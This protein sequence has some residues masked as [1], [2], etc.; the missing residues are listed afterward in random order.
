MTHFL[1][2][3]I[4]LVCAFTHSQ[5]TFHSNGLEVT[6]SDLELNTFQKDS[7]AN[8]LVIYEV[9]NSYVDKE[10]FKL[11]TEIKR[12]VKI[13]N[14]N[15]FD[16]GELSIYLYTSDDRRKE[17]VTDIRATVYNIENGKIQKSKLDKNSI[18][19]QKYNDNYTIMKVAF[20]NIQEGSVINYSYTIISPFFFKY[21]GWNF[22]DDIPKL[23]SEYNASIPGNWFYNIKLVGGQKLST[24]IS[25]IEKYCLSVSGGGSANCAVYKYVMKDIPAFIEEDYMT[26]RQNYLARIEYELATFTSFN[27]VK[28]NITK[29]WESTDKEIER[30]TDLGKQLKKKGAVKELLNQEITSE[31]DQLKKAKAIFKFVQEQYAWNKEYLSLNDV[32]IKETIKNGSGSV[33]EINT[34]LY[35]LLVSNDIDAQAILI[36]TR[37]NGLITKIYPVLSEFNYIIIKANIDGETYLLDAT[38]D[39]VPFGQIPYRCLNQYGRT[40]DFDEGSQW[41]NISIDDYS[42]TQYRYQLKFDENQ[43][44]SGDVGYNSRG[45]HALNDKKKYLNSPDAVDEL[46]NSYSDIDIS[47]FKIVDTDKTSNEFNS[48]FHIEWNPDTVANTIYINPFLFQFFTENPFKL[49]ERSYPI[50]FGYKDSF[51]YRIQFEIDEGYH[52]KELPESVNLALDTNKGSFVMSANEKGNIITI[53]FKLTFNESIYGYNYYDSLKKLMARVV[54]VQKNSLI[55]LEKK[56]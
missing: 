24:N 56:Q 48:K 20:P 16:R 39:Y 4:L 11:H 21:H 53:Y 43:V 40:L 36:S 55:V 33:G 3:F 35:N 7:T 27:G 10:T 50:D 22:Q 23:Y 14:R 38:D 18:Y 32:D 1:R 28:D 17:K 47:D 13:L 12:K 30:E 5:T 41:F 44:L 25:D 34:I 2:V 26:T 29:S 8:A 54:D 31:T 45:Y 49:Q 19:E 42:I 9:G 37:N 46:I 15:G 6:K 51:S 52:I